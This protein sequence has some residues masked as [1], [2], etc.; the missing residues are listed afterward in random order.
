MGT[1]LPCVGDL[2]VRSWTE[3]TQ[4]L[5]SPLNRWEEVLGLRCC[6]SPTAQE[7]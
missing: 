4:S 3:E 2:K 7:I 6:Q 1:P 5:N